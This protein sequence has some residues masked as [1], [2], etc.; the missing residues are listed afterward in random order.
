M[1]NDVFAIIGWLAALVGMSAGWFITWR[2][3]RPENKG[4]K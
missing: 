4:V 3:T 2:A 1:S